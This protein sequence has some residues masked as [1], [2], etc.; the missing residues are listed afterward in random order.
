M[1]LGV[2][3]ITSGNVA[4]FANEMDIKEPVI[5]EE[6]LDSEKVYE[7]VIEEIV[8]DSQVS[9]TEQV[10]ELIDEKVS[11]TIIVSL[12]KFLMNLNLF[13]PT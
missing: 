10:G 13:I 6:V 9:V 2:E 4:C 3:E 7:V 8:E 11:G 12:L 5:A 1:Q